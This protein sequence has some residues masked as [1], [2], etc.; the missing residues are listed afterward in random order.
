ML[1]LRAQSIRAYDSDN[2]MIAATVVEGEAVKSTLQKMFANALV[3][4][5]H[6]HNARPGCFNCK[7]V[8]A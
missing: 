6:L 4:E 1:E 7:A 3:V 5:V 2:M 8:R